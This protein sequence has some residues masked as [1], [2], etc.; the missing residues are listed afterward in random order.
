MRQ[1]AEGTVAPLGNRWFGTMTE[2]G[3]DKVAVVAFDDPP[4]RR[5]HTWPMARDPSEREWQGWANDMMA[6][7]RRRVGQVR[8]K[9]ERKTKRK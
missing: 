1:A 4:L 7:Y 3:G 6:T 9:G 8:E 5:E 2:H